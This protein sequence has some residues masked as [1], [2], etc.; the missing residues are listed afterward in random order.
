MLEKR[1]HLNCAAPRPLSKL[2][3]LAT[4][5]LVEALTWDRVRPHYHSHTSAELQRL[6]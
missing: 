6:H 3:N 5:T 2:R 1:A 4:K